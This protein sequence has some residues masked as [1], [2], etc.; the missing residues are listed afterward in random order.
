M[1]MNGTELWNFQGNEELNKSSTSVRGTVNLLLNHLNPHDSR[2]LI[3]FARADPSEFPSFP[4][5]PSAVQAIADAVHS[6]NF[7]SYPSTRGI[8]PARR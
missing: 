6:S 8:L 1:E 3:P 5:S 7:N 4:T 2:P